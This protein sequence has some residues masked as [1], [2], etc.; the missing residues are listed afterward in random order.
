MVK[1]LIAFENA[2]LLFKNFSGKEG[3]YNREGDRNFCVVIPDDETVSRMEK[4]GWNIRWTKPKEGSEYEPVPYIQVKVSYKKSEP[5]IVLIA[6]ENGEP[7]SKKELGEDDINVLDY[8]YITNVPKIVIS[9]YNYE[10]GGKTG[11]TAY[12]RKLYVSFEVDP[13]EMKYKD[14]PDSAMTSFE[15]FYD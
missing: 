14:V 4:D 7:I 10:V 2:R 11:V 9:P 5:T 6:E 13:L 15:R 12:L 3:K 8:T 1:G